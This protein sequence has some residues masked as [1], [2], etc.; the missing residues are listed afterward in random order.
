MGGKA[1]LKTC[2]QVLG[3]DIDGNPLFVAPPSSDMLPHWP[4]VHEQ[5]C[6]EMDVTRVLYE[7]EIVYAIVSCST[8]V[9]CNPTSAPMEYMNPDSALYASFESAS[10]YPT[11]VKMESLDPTMP[12]TC[13][14]NDMD[15]KRHDDDD[16]DDCMQVKPEPVE[17]T[18]QNSVGLDQV[19]QDGS[20][21]QQQEEEPVYHRRVIK[22]EVHQDDQEMEE[23]L[24]DTVPI[25]TSPAH[26][27][28]PAF[29]A[30]PPAPV[31]EEVR[32]EALSANSR[33]LPPP[34]M[35]PS[36]SQ[37]IESLNA[38]P[39]SMDLEMDVDAF[40]DGAFE[41]LQ[42][43]KKKDKETKLQQAQEADQKRQE[44]EIATQENRR[45]EQERQE[46]L[47]ERI[48][49]ETADYEARLQRQTDY[50][51]GLGGGN[52]HR[53]AEMEDS[54]EEPVV[55]SLE[56][57]EAPEQDQ[58]S[59][60]PATESHQ[61]EAPVDYRND[62]TVI[63]VVEPNP[64]QGQFS[65]IIYR[66][67]EVNP[68]PPPPANGIVNYKKF[69]KVKQFENYSSFEQSQVFHAATTSSQ[70]NN[71]RRARGKQESG[72]PCCG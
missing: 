48:A 50:N 68:R 31:A 56:D 11:S 39:A 36:I 28:S 25:S 49:R 8:N 64:D 62:P 17:S 60:A 33:P 38:I 37:Q 55:E 40:L 70:N 12:V 14:H 26:D 19:E 6:K 63:D 30:E 59:S 20:Q 43:Q 52:V 22:E 15:Y 41:N 66:N 67:L 29:A 18:L 21:R 53:D 42:S 58:S 16:E 23:S 57:Q 27:S 7:Q 72:C 61:E 35:S 13:P 2:E 47:R 1:E 71:R 4:A 69:K 9:M 54:T 3:S 10:L 51:A 44:E 46:L 65:R 32:E 34:T 24:A 5:Y 45:K